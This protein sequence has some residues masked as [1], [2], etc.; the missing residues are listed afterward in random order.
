MTTTSWQLSTL[1]AHQ[2]IAL[3]STRI[4]LNTE[5]LRKRSDRTDYIRLVSKARPTPQEKQQLE[6]ARQRI[7]Q[8]DLW[9]QLAVELEK[10]V[11]RLLEL[12]RM[13]LRSKMPIK[14]KDPYAGLVFNVLASRELSAAGSSSGFVHSRIFIDPLED[15]WTELAHEDTYSECLSAA[16]E[17]RRELV[18]ANNAISKLKEQVKGLRDKLSRVL[19]HSTLK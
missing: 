13:L 18:D 4:T 1:S 14:I 2:R 12:T 9:E 19:N 16:R 3:V 11:P 15:E 8:V 17:V 6:D 5:S 10:I 7:E